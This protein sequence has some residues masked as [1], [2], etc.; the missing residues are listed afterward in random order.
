MVNETILHQ[1]LQLD[2][3]NAAIILCASSSPPISSSSKVFHT[4]GEEKSEAG[5]TLATLRRLFSLSRGN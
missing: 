5:A 1:N 2:S 3:Y 4:Q